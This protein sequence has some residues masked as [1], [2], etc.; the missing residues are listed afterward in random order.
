MSLDLFLLILVL[1]AGFYMAWNIGAND[2][3]NAMGTSVGSGALT[4]RQAVY[5][6]AFLEF[7]GAFFFGSNVSETVQKGIVDVSTF[8]DNPHLL[9]YGMLA[10]L[11]SA[12]V[13][14]QIASYY[15]W[16]VSTT[17]TIVGSIVGFGVVSGGVD[18][19]HWDNVGFI[20][21]SWVLSPLLGGILSF[22]IFSGLRKAIFYAQDPLEA[23]KKI[24]PLIVFGVVIIL[25][26]I[27]IFNGFHNLE[28][29]LTTPQ[30][31]WISI[32]VATIFSYV[33]YLCVKRLSVKEN[34]VKTDLEYIDLEYGAVE[35]IFAY[36]QI[37]SACLMAFAHG[38]NDVA[39]AIGPLS[40][41]LPCLKQE[42]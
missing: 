42:L 23:A 15:G 11:I 28:L 7:G 26:M 38:A 14:L 13:W 39:N 19:I 31:F 34:L 12:G 5:V 22:L 33:S 30:V 6:A 21:S 37:M 16:P 27:L 24:T 29:K 20:V 3:A 1:T 32:I 8:A 18:A 40:A 25:M 4:L 2:V 10:S 35:K 41:A 9:V 36:L 17:H